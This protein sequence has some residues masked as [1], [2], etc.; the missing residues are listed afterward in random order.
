MFKWI[1][2][3]ITGSLGPLGLPIDPLYEWIIMG[4]VGFIVHEIAW[5]TS[6]G[7]RWGSLIYWAT[8]L[9]VIFVI[10]AILRVVI[11]FY[12]FFTAHIWLLVLIIIGVMIIAI[13]G[14]KINKA[15]K[16]KNDAGHDR[17]KN[18]G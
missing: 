2:E 15:R 13:M 8:K 3:L 5:N 12:Y 10:W 1:Y 7:G 14:M 11:G 9:V 4:V 17:K 18:E 16:G 6:P